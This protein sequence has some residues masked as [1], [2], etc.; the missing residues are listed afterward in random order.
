MKRTLIIIMLV[1]LSVPGLVYS[2][3]NILDRIMLSR[4][5][6][7][8]FRERVFRHD[9]PELKCEYDLKVMRFKDELLTEYGQ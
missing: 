9:N 4:E 5:L 1:S 7:V 8:S 6:D 3:C 2:G